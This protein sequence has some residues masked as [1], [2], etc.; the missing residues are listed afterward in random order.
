MGVLGRTSKYE[1]SGKASRYAKIKATRAIFNTRAAQLMGLENKFH[2]VN[3]G[4]VTIVNTTA[5]AEGPAGGA[6]ALNMIQQG[7]TAT[8]RDGRKITVNWVTVHG[9]LTCAT[10]SDQ[11]DA[12]PNVSVRLLLVQDT[13]T[14]GIALNSEDVL[15]DNSSIPIN[16]MRNLEFGKRFKVHKDEFFD[17]KRTNVGNDGENTMSIQGDSVAFR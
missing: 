13:Q 15:K 10:K 14:N 4:T 2:D 11:T 7:D 8:T 12:L 9:N 5:G 1:K 3:T 16:D 17:L 6:T